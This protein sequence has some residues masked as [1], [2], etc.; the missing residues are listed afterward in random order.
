MIEN[1]LWPAELK[2]PP[3][4][5]VN[6]DAMF[7]TIK[8]EKPKRVPLI[9]A[10]PYDGYPP[11]IRFWGVNVDSLTIGLIFDLTKSGTDGFKGHIP[12]MFQNMG[13]EIVGC[14]CLGWHA[15]TDDL[16]SD[17]N[18]ARETDPSKLNPA[19]V[20]LD[21]QNY[22]FENGETKPLFVMKGKGLEDGGWLPQFGSVG[23]Y[24]AISYVVN[25]AF[26]AY[27]MNGVFHTMMQEF[28]GEQLAIEIIIRID[29]VV[30][31]TQDGFYVGVYSGE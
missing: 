11:T 22:D 16:T 30:A 5:L 13:H 31:I 4:L 14:R 28:V 17:P 19:P 23:A 7:D 21:F 9:N 26:I 15:A 1:I 29:P 6:P 18:D 27:V 25:K 8:Q 12:L 10:A 24:S 3:Y 20:M 2:E